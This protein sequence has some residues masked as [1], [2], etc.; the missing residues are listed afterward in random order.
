MK[1]IKL[2]FRVWDGTG[3]NYEDSCWLRITGD[4]ILV[5]G[6]D[7]SEELQNGKL[8]LMQYTR[9]KDKNGKEIFEGDIVEYVNYNER[10]LSEI[11]DMDEYGV[12]MD[13]TNIIPKRSCMEMHGN[14]N[15]T[16]ISL[17]SENAKGPIAG[18]DDD[19]LDC[20]ETEV[21]GNI[22]QDRNLLETKKA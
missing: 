18:G 7:W 3:M 20:N 10:F 5:N 14:G 13:D 17:R 9:L 8:V 4:N 6:F 1:K 2:K 22:Y 15:S 12:Q 21:I 19:E 11:L 16:M